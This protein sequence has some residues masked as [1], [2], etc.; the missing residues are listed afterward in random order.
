MIYKFINQTLIFMVNQKKTTISTEIYKI[1]KDF[2]HYFNHDRA[3]RRSSIYPMLK[4]ETKNDTS[5]N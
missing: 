5:N 3:S 2:V 1:N 4:I